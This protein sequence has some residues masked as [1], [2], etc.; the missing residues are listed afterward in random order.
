MRNVSEVLMSSSHGDFFLPFR[1]ARSSPPLLV[2]G[3]GSRATY[4]LQAPAR[5]R[6]HPNNRLVGTV[7]PVSPMRRQ[8]QR[9][10]RG[11]S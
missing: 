1:A 10:A 8:A 3:T 5:R 6:A 11:G 9:G 4:E 7:T 2:N